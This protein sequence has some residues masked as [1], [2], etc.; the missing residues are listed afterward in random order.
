MLPCPREIAFLAVRSHK[1]STGHT[2]CGSG[3]VA[4][5]FI[6]GVSCPPQGHELSVH[7]NGAEVGNRQFHWLLS[8]GRLEWW[9]VATWKGG[10]FANYFWPNVEYL[11]RLWCSHICNVNHPLPP[12]KP[13]PDSVRYVRS[14]ISLVSNPHHLPIT[15]SK[16]S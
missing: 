3:R 15:Q 13:Q 11:P 4:R 16:L 7:D 1:P 14:L 10:R 12:K 6:S 9:M 2:N 5:P 8:N